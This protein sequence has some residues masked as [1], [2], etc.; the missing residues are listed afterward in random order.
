[1]RGVR[2]DLRGFPSVW[3]SIMELWK[4]TETSDNYVNVQGKRLLI[5]SMCKTWAKNVLLVSYTYYISS[6]YILCLI[7][8]NST[9]VRTLSIFLHSYFC[10]DTSSTNI[11]SVMA[12]YIAS[13]PAV[14]SLVDVCL[15]ITWYKSHTFSL[16][17]KT[18]KDP[19]VN[20]KSLLAAIFL[21]YF[22]YTRTLYMSQVWYLIPIIT[23]K[24]P[25]H[26]NQFAVKTNRRP[27]KVHRIPITF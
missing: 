17:H 3:K 1:M 5:S 20:L 27:V 19:L 24:T 4:W 8:T 26:T 9:P 10:G 7:H 14:F 6:Y 12:L 16:Y 13:C 2:W 22:S 21:W 15:W 11:D 25:C 23:V 18:L